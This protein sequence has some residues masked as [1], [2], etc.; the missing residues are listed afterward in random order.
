MASTPTRPNL[1]LFF[2]DQ[3]RHDFIG[4][5]PDVPVR[6]PNLDRLAERG[7]RF[8]N[9]VTPS[10]GCG[11]ARACLASGMEYEHC[12]LSLNDDTPSFDPTTT[13]YARLRDEADYEVLGVGKFLHTFYDR[14]GPEGKHRIEE[15]G[16]TDGVRNRGNW[17]AVADVEDPE[18]H[19]YMR[20]LAEQNLLETHREDFAERTETLVHTYAATFPTPLPEEAYCDN[21]LAANG[22]ELLEG[23]PTDRPW[24]LEVS[25][26]GPHNPMDVTHEMHGWYRGS[27]AVDFPG[28]SPLGPD[29][30]LDS[31][32][33]NEIRRNYAAQCENVDR[34]LGR[35]LDCLEERGELEETIICFTSDHGDLLGDNGRWRKGSPYH[36]SVGVPLVIA[37]PG[38]RGTGPTPEPASVLDVHATFL[39]YAGLDAD[40]ADSTSL[41]PF[42][43]DATDHHREAVTSSIGPWQMAFDGR[44]KLI[45]GFDP[46]K[47]SSQALAGDGE[48]L[49]R[50]RDLPDDERAAYRAE[51]PTLLFDH[52]SDPRETV[53]VAPDRPE[54]VA[55]L[56]QHLTR[57]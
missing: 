35:Y 51:Q 34:W 57:F 56:D 52:A 2:T 11:P 22:L 17:N 38:V 15:F 47:K 33:H 29:D 13:H 20:Y 19:V 27:D 18:Q 5:S 54:T 21:W 8:E 49:G 48:Q 3:Q 24:H 45:R 7:V 28:P 39:D 9:A 44:H 1:L 31:H 30:L 42:L 41:R 37:G 50:Y 36:G 4:P 6:T 14:Y 25:F 12:G 55:K 53:N 23:T 40:G 10:P 16:F 43:E 46:G 26:T 32:T